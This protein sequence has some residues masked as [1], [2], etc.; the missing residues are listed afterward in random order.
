[1][2]FLNEAIKCRYC[3]E[4]LDGRTAS[5][6]TGY[7]IP[8]YLGYEFRSPVDILGMPLVHIAY[9]VNPTTGL[10][11]VARGFIAIGNIAIGVF[12]IGGFVLGLFVLTGIGLGLVTIG[13]I[14]FGA[15]AAFGGIS[16]ALWL[17][18]GGVA[19]SLQYAI[20][21]V[22]LAPYTISTLGVSRQAVEMISRWWL[23]VR[24]LFP[25]L[26]T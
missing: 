18:V 3:G 19:L 24:E 16:M 7:V 17:A 10:P 14:A 26:N 25:D 15:L 13:G 8:V 1:M 4:F 5:I 21:G 23:G 11:R 12:A 2:F 6:S 20:G 9:G 22:A